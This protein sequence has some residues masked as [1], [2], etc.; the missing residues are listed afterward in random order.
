MEGTNKSRVLLE[1]AIIGAASLPS[2]Y[3]TRGIVR[4]LL[5]RF[6]SGT[7]EMISVFLSG[8]AFYFVYEEMGWSEWAEAMRKDRKREGTNIPLSDDLCDGS[9]G[10]V[11]DGLCSHYSVHSPVPVE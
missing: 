11:P 2:Y 8:G 9:C 1:A 3:I 7:Q 10:W 6:S 4:T 5:P